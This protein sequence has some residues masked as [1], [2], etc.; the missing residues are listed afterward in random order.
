M[1]H[2]DLLSKDT[3]A[4]LAD[5]YP[6]LASTDVWLWGLVA[7][8]FVLD[9][10]LTYHGLGLGLEERNPIVRRLFAVLGVLET[11]V[12]MKALVVAMALIAWVSI[13]DRYRPVIPLGVSLPWLVASAINLSLILRV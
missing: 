3:S 10:A 6:F 2:S 1:V 5:E 7:V 9:I 4:S 8:G 13:P 11:M 12:L